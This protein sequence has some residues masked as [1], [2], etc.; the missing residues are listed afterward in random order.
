MWGTG[1]RFLL[2]RCL[3]TSRFFHPFE[4]SGNER[5]VERGLSLNDHLL[6]SEHETCYSSKCQ[7]HQ[8]SKWQTTTKQEQRLRAVRKYVTGTIVYYG[9]TAQVT[10]HMRQ[11]RGTHEKLDCYK[12]RDHAVTVLDCKTFNS[13][14]YLQYSEMANSSTRNGK[15]SN[16]S[17]SSKIVEIRTANQNPSTKRHARRKPHTWKKWSGRV[18]GAPLRIGARR[19]DLNVSVLFAGLLRQRRP[20]NLA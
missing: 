13:R 3:R 12:Q 4:S 16:L 10:S 11:L 5:V 15:T 20:G 17:K 9:T 1:K 7:T 8:A 19:D 14:L 6:W 2:S 18:G